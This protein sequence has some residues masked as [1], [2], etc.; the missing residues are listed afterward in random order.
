[1]LYP[2]RCHSCSFRK[3]GVEEIRSSV[4]PSIIETIYEALER[5]IKNGAKT[6]VVPDVMIPSCVVLDLFPDPDLAVYMILKT[7]QLYA[8][9]Q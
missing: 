5:L 4:M 9:V 7:E 6:L 1:M 2:P 8:K 3:M